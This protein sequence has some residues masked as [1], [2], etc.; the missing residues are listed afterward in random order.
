MIARAGNIYKAWRPR[1]TSRSDHL[2]LAGLVL[3][4]TML[5]GEAVAIGDIYEIVCVCVVYNFLYTH[6]SVHDREHLLPSH[7]PR[8]V[9]YC[10]H[11]EA[12][13]VIINLMIA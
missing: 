4:C 1:P 6:I 8:V 11:S 12:L 7:S 2:L 9:S 10:C 5:S 3:G 13:T